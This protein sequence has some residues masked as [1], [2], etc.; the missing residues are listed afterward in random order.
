[1]N[2]RIWLSESLISMKENEKLNEI[3]L[4]VKSLSMDLYY[5]DIQKVNREE[6][7]MSLQDILKLQGAAMFSKMTLFEVAW[8]INDE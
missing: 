4:I 8:K 2:V 3:S 7:A 5:G 6:S 1:M